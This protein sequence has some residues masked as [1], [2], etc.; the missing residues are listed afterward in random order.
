VANTFKILEKESDTRTTNTKV[1][2]QVSGTLPVNG[3]V[4]GNNDNT[5][6]F[7]PPGYTS[8][9][10]T[11]FTF[12]TSS[13]FVDVNWGIRSGC[14]DDV[15]SMFFKSDNTYGG[16]NP[17]VLVGEGKFSVSK[18]ASMV[19]KSWASQL[20]DGDDLEI[21]GEKIDLVGVFNFKRS[22]YRDRLEAGTLNIGFRSSG[23]TFTS[24][25]DDGAK[26]IQTSKAG[27]YSFVQNVGGGDNS[28]TINVGKM[29]HDKA[30]VV[31]DLFKTFFPSQTDRNV[32]NQSVLLPFI[33][34]STNAGGIASIHNI[35]F[36]SGSDV[37]PTGTEGRVNKR[38]RYKG[39]CPHDILSFYSA[40]Y[41]QSL[42][43]LTADFEGA[44]VNAAVNFKT[45]LYFCRALHNEYNYS[46]NPTYSTGS[47][48]N[49]QTYRLE[50]PET[51]VT[52]I[53]LF[54]NSN[55]CLAVGKLSQPLRKDFGRES[56]IRLRLD[57]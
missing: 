7:F 43:T 6:V 5:M 40:S 3:T 14:F 48:D 26:Q 56:V 27:P 20:N 32:S 33:T 42:A 35:G 44:R 11:W 31:L 10:F 16:Q 45:K 46:T 41:S 30:V 22:Q 39:S 57:F 54:N 2:V 37:L 52:T 47:T 13:K 4:G 28:T 15:N 29:Y 23:S 24:L 17:D 8:P 9:N 38:A 19:Y 1:T 55:E 53:G 21:E 36:F 25:T 49:T 12:N 34:G 18:T 51:F 50:E